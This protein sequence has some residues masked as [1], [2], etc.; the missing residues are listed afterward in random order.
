MADSKITQLNANTSPASGDLLVIVDDPGGTAETQKIDHDNLFKNIKMLNLRDPTELTI[1]GGEIT[2][3]QSFHT[4]D[5]E[6][7][8]A[9]DDLDTISGGSEGDILIIA[10]QAVGRAIVVK[11]GTGNLALSGDFDLNANNDRL[12]LIRTGSGWAELSRSNN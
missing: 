9:S 4:V 12:M 5:T 1:S 6:G 8:A 10:R 2:V 3:T 11:D 7:D